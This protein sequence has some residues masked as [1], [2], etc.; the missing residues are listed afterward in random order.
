MKDFLAA[1]TDEEV[2]A[3]VAGMKAVQREGLRAAKHMRGEIYEIV[4]DARTRSFRLLFA[5]EGRFGQVFLS[6]SGFVKKTRK[7]PPRELALAESR[8]RSWRARGGHDRS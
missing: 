1:L 7:T 5:P 2:A 6:L 4:A 3:I 8:L